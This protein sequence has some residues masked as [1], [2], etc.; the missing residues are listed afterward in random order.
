MK[1][2]YLP[3]ALVVAFLAVLYFYNKTKN[4]EN[5]AN[6]LFTTAQRG[7]FEVVVTATGEL[8]A[9]NSEK[10][11]TPSGMMTA[12]VYEVT[13]SDMVPE[14][15][16]VAAGDYVATLDQTELTNKIKA[17]QSELEKAESQITQSA[18]DTAIELRQLRDQIVNLQYQ[19]E[20]KKLQM[21]QNIYEAPAIIRQ[22]Q[23]E[24]ER[25]LRDISQATENKLLKKQ[26]A[27][28]KLTE[29]NATLTQHKDKLIQLMELSNQFTVTA[30]KGGMV[31]YERSWN[32]KKS[33]GSVCAQSNR[34]PSF[35]RCKNGSIQL[36]VCPPA[37]RR[38]YIAY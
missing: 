14:G 27:S 18:L 12:Q 32:G 3:I 17:E 37:R 6:I 30:P 13:I 31:I 4:G 5:E 7:D 33:T 2:Y 1:K 26:Q 11:V 25:V 9:K 24:Y 34:R 28:A 10:I 19:L 21:E 15:T 23:L 29:I 38:C 22:T 36:F 16:I 8:L 20:E 35:R